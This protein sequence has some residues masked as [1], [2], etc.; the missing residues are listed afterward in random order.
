MFFT[1]SLFHSGEPLNPIKQDTK[2]GKLRDVAYPYPF[3]YGAFPQTW[4]DPTHKDDSTDAF[5]DN[6]PIDVCELSGVVR[7]TG[8]V[9]PV[10]VL[11]TLAMID[12]GETDWKIIAIALDSPLAEKWD[13]HEDVPKEKKEEVFTFLRDY[14]IPDGKPANVFAFDGAYQD[15]DFA[16]K[17]IEETANQWTK[18]ATGAIPAKTEKYDLSIANTTLDANQYPGSIAADTAE[19]IVVDAFTSYVAKH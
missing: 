12:D 16:M 17:K 6:D 18:L 1:C 7:K 2:N 9:V 13:S 11:G 15:K 4:E 5:G 8:D 14:K 19:K 10:K 3:N